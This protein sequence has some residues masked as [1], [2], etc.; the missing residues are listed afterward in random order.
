M[1]DAVSKKFEIEDLICERE[2]IVKHM[3]LYHERW[4]TKLGYTS[5]SIYDHDALP[6]LNILVAE[7]EKDNLLVE[8]CHLYLDCEFTLPFLN[9]IE[10]AC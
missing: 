2:K 6:L 7:T 4:F 10:L 1:T 5:A 9:C 8:A 3:S